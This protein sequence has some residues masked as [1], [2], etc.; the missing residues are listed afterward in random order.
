M[1]SMAPH[2]VRGS[3]LLQH[4]AEVCPCTGPT[5]MSGS[6]FSRAVAHWYPSAGD[7]RMHPSLTRHVPVAVHAPSCCQEKQHFTNFLNFVLFLLWL[8]SVHSLV[9]ALEWAENE[10]QMGTEHNRMLLFVQDPLCACLSPKIQNI[11]RAGST[12]QLK[13]RIKNTLIELGGYT[14]ILIFRKPVLEGKVPS[15][16]ASQ[17]AGR[18]AWACCCVSWAYSTHCNIKHCLGNVSFLLSSVQALQSPAAPCISQGYPKGVVNRVS[19][20]LCIS[21]T[22]TCATVTR[23]SLHPSRSLAPGSQQWHGTSRAGSRALT[24]VDAVTWLWEM[25]DFPQVSDS[26]H[27]CFSLISHGHTF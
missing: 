25:K 16:E 2:D 21:T 1:G 12:A 27:S 3:R 14:Y 20:C 22:R 17:Q 10:L 19:L 23:I 8:S 6:Q 5:P 4:W 13:N 7:G 11:A 24:H 18:R 15:A 26:R 9:G